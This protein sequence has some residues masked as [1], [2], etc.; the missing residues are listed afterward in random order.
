VVT[1]GTVPCRAATTLGGFFVLGKGVVELKVIFTILV[2]CFLMGC[3]AP[4]RYG[5]Y[6]DFQDETVT[7]EPLRFSSDPILDSTYRDRYLEMLRRCGSGDDR[8][9]K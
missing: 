7:E 5:D 4:H 6:R 2:L 3:G 8:C 1:H 9:R